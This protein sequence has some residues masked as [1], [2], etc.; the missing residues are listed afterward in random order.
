MVR[1]GSVDHGTARARSSA[2]YG[3]PRPDMIAETR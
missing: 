3:V 2:R 1:E